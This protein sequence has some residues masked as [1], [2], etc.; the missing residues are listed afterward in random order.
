MEELWY[1]IKGYE[2][3]YEITKSGNIRSKPR[4]VN[5]K[6]NNTRFVP[7]KILSTRVNNRGYISTELNTNNIG[8]CVII[9]VLIARTFI[10]NPENKPQVN[11]INGIKTDNRIENLEWCTAK[12]NRIHAINTGLSKSFKGSD[13]YN[14][15]LT[16]DEIYSIRERVKN[17]E[18]QLN[19]ALEYNVHVGTIHKIHKR[20][21][22]K[23][24]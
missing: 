14:V 23:H 24:I 5:F 3:Y 6:I 12:E 7:P 16:K 8:K 11:H 19:L 22:W 21:T 20:I 13:N 17:H 10:P 15:K 2:D 9:H 18:S 4:R 1:D